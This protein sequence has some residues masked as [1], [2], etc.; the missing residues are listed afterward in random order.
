MLGEWAS[1]FA[2]VVTG[3][4]RRW[5][6][7]DSERRPPPRDRREPL[8]SGPWPRRPTRHLAAHF[9]RTRRRTF[10]KTPAV[11]GSD[12]SPSG[13]TRNAGRPPHPRSDRQAV[14]ARSN[15]RLSGTGS[16]E[17]D[18]TARADPGSSHQE[19]P[20]AVRG[21]DRRDPTADGSRHGDVDSAGARAGIIAAARVRGSDR[22]VQSQRLGVGAG[23]VA[24]REHP[25]GEE[26]HHASQGRSRCRRCRRVGCILVRRQAG[27][28]ADGACGVMMLRS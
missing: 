4:G 17:E 21:E 18:R 6:V 23:T 22:D 1:I 13:G 19:D 16:A 12:C 2:G 7:L 9:V 20:R 28:Q 5:S 26:A 27:R 3:S 10:G 11:N 15:G 25:R 14:Q 8:H 24:R